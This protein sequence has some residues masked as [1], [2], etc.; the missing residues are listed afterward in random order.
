METLPEVSAALDEIGGVFQWEE[1]WT[2][3]E[4]PESA[5]QCVAISRLGKP[6]G[7]PIVDLELTGR[8]ER[9]GFEWAE[10]SHWTR[11]STQCDHQV[12]SGYDRSKESLR[13][14]ADASQPA[15]KML[16]ALVESAPVTIVRSFI[17]D[18]PVR[19]LSVELRWSVDGELFVRAWG[20]FE[21]GAA[22]EVTERLSAL[23]A[24]HEAKDASQPYVEASASDGTWALSVLQL[25]PDPPWATVPGAE[26]LEETRPGV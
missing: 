24:R 11:G 12:A 3:E 19:I 8:L 17:A 23:A 9:L 4:D 21:S 13:C 26:A 15:A 20:A 22:A 5:R 25:G 10:A 14:C 6:G 2:A 18:A 1:S 16:D 7:D